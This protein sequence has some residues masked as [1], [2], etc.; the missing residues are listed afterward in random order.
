MVC[1]AVWDLLGR[2]AHDHDRRDLPRHVKHPQKLTR[3]WKSGHQIR[4]KPNVLL[5]CFLGELCLHLSPHYVRKWQHDDR[6]QLDRILSYNDSLSNSPGL[7]GHVWVYQHGVAWSRHTV[8]LLARWQQKVKWCS[9]D[10]NKRAPEGACQ[11]RG[12]QSCRRRREANLHEAARASRVDGRWA[13]AGD[14]RID[15]D[16]QGRWLSNQ[17]L[18]A[19]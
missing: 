19:H 10:L 17:H 2:C 5:Y 8:A 3:P 15:D 6:Y 4:Q 18:E 9:E 14:F 1:Y 7:A 11:S 12:R 16:A 13:A